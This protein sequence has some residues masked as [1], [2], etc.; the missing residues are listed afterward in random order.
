MLK[1]YR[2]LKHFLTCSLLFF[3]IFTSLASDYPSN[4]I[5]NGNN[6]TEIS[7]TL[8]HQEKST[9]N[10]VLTLPI[11]TDTTY[12]F[13]DTELNNH[14]L[15]LLT[16]S[17]TNNTTQNRLRIK[18]NY[19][20][21]YNA[22]LF[23]I[24]KEGK[25]HQLGKAQGNAH[26]LSSNNYIDFI[27]EI[28]LQSGATKKYILATNGK[29]PLIKY[30]V[31]TANDIAIIEHAQEKEIITFIYFAICLVMLLYNV[32]LSFSTRDRLYTFYVLFLLLNCIT[33]L[34]IKGFT[35][36][37]FWEGNSFMSL[38]NFMFFLP[39][40][41]QSGTI[42]IRQFTN[43]K[44]LIPK[45]DSF[46]KYIPLIATVSCIGVV[47]IN[48]NV[49]YFGII[50][51]S[52]LWGWLSFIIAIS[53]YLKGNK[54]SLYV[55]I[56]QSVYQVG[57]TIFVLAINGDIPNTMFTFYCLEFGSA[58][59]LVF[60][61]LSLADRINTLKKDKDYS[62]QQAL[63]SERK[64]RQELVNR[65]VILEQQVEQQTAELRTTNFEL[66][67]QALSA[68]I[69][70]HFIFN[71]LNS[72]QSYI[73]DDKK[74]EAE[75]YIAK[76]SRLMRFYLDSSVK[77]TI[78]LKSEIEALERYLQLEQLRFDN[79]FSYTVY[80]DNLSSPAKTHM[81]SMLILPFVENAVWHG[82]R[83]INYH[84]EIA[85]YIRVKS[86]QLLEV[87][88]DDN[89]CGIEKSKEVKRTGHESN[90]IRITKE[91]IHLLHSQIHSVPEI[92]IET[93]LTGVGTLVSFTIPYTLKEE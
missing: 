51:S 28:D 81:G 47:L 83:Q 29:F 27:F 80:F 37:F 55:I 85:I 4:I 17:L 54:S 61:S 21:C 22:V 84:G 75:K 91:R 8:H 49:F 92:K 76:F 42:F 67:R 68:Q 13:Y 40:A 77:P 82:M 14:R 89:G 63:K 3:I 19:F 1:T 12:S 24:D 46:Y 79:S 62:Q 71:V 88:I 48:R 64:Y 2:P 15:D 73:L 56:A 7:F 44:L 25:L 26:S 32:F 30:L 65:K 59:D 35:Y 58:I 53:S 50:I 45:L 23:E 90:G 34:D 6:I 33:Q 69:N 70:P 60:L 57:I 31:Y 93:G 18:L 87:Q 9:T 78:S 86:A 52:T 39:L 74:E 11:N 41:M 36:K 38:N 16:F 20:T 66:K 43:S 5:R 72:I 10:F